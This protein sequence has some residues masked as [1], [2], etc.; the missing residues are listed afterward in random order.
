MWMLPDIKS[1]W[2]TCTVQI[3]W[4]VDVGQGRPLCDL[5]PCSG[6]QGISWSLVRSGQKAAAT[7]PWR[8]W[9]VNLVLSSLVYHSYCLQSGLSPAEGAVVPPCPELHGPPACCCLGPS[10]WDLQPVASWVVVRHWKQYNIL[11]FTSYSWDEMV[12]L[13]LESE[14]ISSLCPAAYPCQLPFTTIWHSFDL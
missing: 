11:V 3:E 7:W 4:G 13:T 12:E 10:P 14:S 8:D 9:G 1:S 2:Q 6:H 5:W